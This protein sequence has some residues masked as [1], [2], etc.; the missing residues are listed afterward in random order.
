MTCAWF[1]DQLTNPR[2]LA[3]DGVEDLDHPPEI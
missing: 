1:S 2:Q 3:L